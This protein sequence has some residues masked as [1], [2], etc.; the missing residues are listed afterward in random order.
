MTERKRRSEATVFDASEATDRFKIVQSDAFRFIRA[1]PPESVDLVVTDPPY[2]SLEKHRAVG[3]TTRLKHS[4]AS[5][6]DWFGVIGNERLPELMSLLYRALKKDR[7]CYVFCDQETMFYLKPAGE[8]AGFKFW[9]PLVWSKKRVGMGYHYRAS[10][11]LV[12]FFEKGKRKLNDLGVKDV[13][14][15]LSIRGGYPAEK[16]KEVSSVLIRQSTQPGE[17]VVDPFMGSASAGVAALELGR[18]FLG[19]DVAPTAFALA[20]ERLAGV[21]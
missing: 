4:K 15:Q 21:P 19:C 14:E 5:S 6:N 1:I 13:I 16:P 12:L 11:E 2:E 3:T 17:V 7:H 9:K 18:T 8:A 10:Y 20:V